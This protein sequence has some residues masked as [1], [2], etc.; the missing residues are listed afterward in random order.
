MILGMKTEFVENYISEIIKHFQTGQAGEH[1]YRPAFKSLMNS[2]LPDL[3]AIND[4]KRSE[5]GAPDFIFMRSKE[6]TA[7][8]A[9]TKDINVNLDD[10]EKSDQMKRYLGY[11][12]LILTNYIEFRFFRYGEKF[13]EPIIVAKLQ[14]NNIEVD[15]KRFGEL[16]DA[17]HDFFSQ[18]E[19]IKSSSKLAKIMGGKARRIRDNIRRFVED[20]NERN[21]EIRN[22]FESFKKLLIHDLRE[23][24]FADMYAQTLVYGLFAARYEDTTPN[25]FT[26]R[27]AR[28][29]IPVSNPFL[30]HFFDHITG[31]SFDDRLAI[32]VNE[33]CEVFSNTDV[34]TLMYEY[35]TQKS[36]LGEDKEFADPVIHFY[37]DFLKEY[38]SDQRKK[39][40]AFY[41]PLPV[42]RFIVRAVDYILKKDFDLLEGL[43]DTSKIEV[44]KNVQGKNTKESLHK[45][46]ILDPAV[47]TGTFLNEVIKNIY[48]RF[49]N[50]EG[51]W[52]SYIENDLLPRIH[53]FELMM[54]PYT[55]AHLKIAMTLK[56]SGHKDF[57]E[58]LGIYL[59][60]SLE[61]SSKS[62]DTLFGPGFGQVIT[63][64]GK[65]ASKIKNEKPIMVVI[66]NPP[67]SG[68]SSN[69]FESAN[70]LVNKY[71]FEPGGV[72]KLKERNPK[73]INDDYVKFI[74]LAE[75]LVEKNGEGILGYIT[76][77][78][79]LD[80]P[81]FRGMR[82]KLANTFDDIYI[83]D[84]HGNSKKKE[85]SPDG[86]KD[87]NVFNIQ[88]G[89]AIIIGVKKRGNKNKVA[90]IYHAETYGKRIK[91]FEY[92]SKEI[93]Y[94]KIDL[95]SKYYFFVPKNIEGKDDYNKGFS[96][97]D[98]FT[99]NSVCIVSGDDEKFIKFKRKEFDPDIIEENIKTLNYRIFDTR[100]INYDL[101]LITRSRIKTMS[102][103]I[104]NDNIGLTFIRNDQG[105]KNFSHIFISNILTDGHLHPGLTYTAPLYLY[106][107]DGSK[108][109]NLKKEIVDEI[110]K[111]IGKAEPEDIFDYIYAVLHSPNYREKYKEFLKIDFPRVPYPKD[112]EFFKKLVELGGELRELH[113]LESPKVKNFITTFTESGSDEVEAKYPKYEKEKVFINAKQYFGNVP[114]IAWNFY[115][116]GYQPAQK[117]LKDRRGRKLISEDFEHY[118]KIIVALVE[119]DRIM[120][121]IDK[122]K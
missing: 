43:A 29:L 12:S 9:E 76:N 34:R 33:L 95:D 38:D 102:H 11:D 52:K 14:N 61:E 88:Q 99:Q 68:E 49:K 16:T 116:G 17:L 122:I 64:E 96:L 56:D 103:F 100:Y 117:W 8:Y 36:L 25:N 73:W 46:Q 35:A 109:P 30:R 69:N 19:P 26:R 91:K 84:L 90:N 57:K 107:E 106:V 6:L 112:V 65:E 104:N 18:T 119:T 115:I 50:Q 111:I 120:K 59:T 114:E 108:I 60:N 40:G 80:N 37:E 53:G 118:Q 41:T 31:S 63:E 101:K 67:Y 79:Y 23:N 81:T 97:Q 2:I 7:G 98:L 85:I 66:G 21:K 121:E 75:N 13:G 32:I 86:T 44:I 93:K 3:Q 28:D 87:E 74:A 105:A 24:Q 42:V 15:E 72:T 83:I 78:A 92:L 48:S 39:L 89:V 71:K 1:A 62:E 58:R 47:G 51:R 5:H 27:E 20:T 113:L 110:E 82:W 22:I 45:V 70:N 94:K 54:A 4:P 77:H 55:I 10:T